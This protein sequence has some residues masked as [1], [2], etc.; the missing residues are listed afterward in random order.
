MAERI[1][2]P[3]DLRLGDLVGRYR[4]ESFLGEGG[5]AR[6]Y[7]VKHADHGHVAALK[8]PRLGLDAEFRE[9]FLLEAGAHLNLNGKRHIVSPLE[10]GTLPEPDGRPYLIMQRVNGVTLEAYMRAPERAGEPPDVLVARSIRFAIQVAMALEVAH[11]LKPPIVHRDLKPS[12]VYVARDEDLNIE[13]REVEYVLL[14]DFGLA[15]RRGD[16][17][18]PVGTPEYCS[19]EQ[20]SSAEPTPRSDLYSLGVLLFELVEGHLPFRSDDVMKLLELHRSSPPPPLRN[21]YA[22]GLRPI[23]AKLLEKHWADRPADAREVINQLTG[24]LLR[25]ERRDQVT[26]IRRM[27]GPEAPMTEQLPAVDPKETARLPRPAAGGAPRAAAGKPAPGEVSPAPANPSLLALE[28]D[29][30]SMGSRPVLVVGF[31][32]LAII[33]AFVA[34]R[35]LPKERPADPPVAVAPPSSAPPAV[36]E[37]PREVKAVPEPGALEPVAVAGEPA[38]REA[39]SADTPRPVAAQKPGCEVSQRWR[40]RRYADLGELQDLH[41]GLGAQGDTSAMS[42]EALEEQVKVLGASITEAQTS[43]HCED[44]IRR[45]AELRRRAL[46]K[47]R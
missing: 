33:A 9:R 8:L 47:K 31:M 16:E 37:P 36:A 27:P 23:V 21:P 10:T 45:I 11:R 34:S 30:K 17:L 12:N 28:R 32:G 20:A 43:A 22:D 26:S 6:V 38:P 1:S 46:P 5:M 42:A 14:G 41:A 18:N 19:P 40:E 39:V 24:A 3:L 29:L 4:I 44:V 7:G 15:W 2:G 13:G 25:L 35:V